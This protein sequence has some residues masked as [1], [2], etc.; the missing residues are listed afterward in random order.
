M[1]VTP[2]EHSAPW[3]NFYMGS[4]GRMEARS[5]ASRTNKALVT[6]RYA[7]GSWRWG[8]TTCGWGSCWANTL[9]PGGRAAHTGNFTLEKNSSALKALCRTLK[10][11][12]FRNVSEE[13]TIRKLKLLKLKRTL[14]E[15]LFLQV[16]GIITKVLP[17]MHQ[18]EINWMRE[19]IESDGGMEDGT[20]RD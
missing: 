10:Q 12:S 15:L 2:R 19:E 4:S 18:S 16:R 13:N 11:K 1:T 5:A 6:A 7:P 3:S 17:L 8:S 9:E 14:V 20:E